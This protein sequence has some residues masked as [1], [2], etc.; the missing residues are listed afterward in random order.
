MDD[1]T[2]D[3]RQLEAFAAVMSAGSITGAA[4]LLGRSQPAVTRLIQELESDLGFALLHR[5]GPRITP[6]DKGVSF[7]EEIDRL[8]IGLRHIRDRADAIAK[9]KTPAIEVTATQSL[10]AG[11]VPA[12]LA[13]LKEADF[14][15]QVHLRASSAEDVVQSVIS[16]TADIGL[17]SLPIDHPG[18]DIHWIGEIACVAVMRGD[19]DL[20]SHDVLPLAALS[21][22]RII[23]MANP[24]RLRRR[25]DN[26][27][28]EA[29]LVPTE[30]IETNASLN[31][32]MSARAGLGV[33][34]VD[35]ATAFGIPIDGMVV[36]PLDI[37][38][39]FLFGVVTSAGHPLSRTARALIDAI[40][41]TA[42]DL[43]PAL[44]SRTPADMDG[45]TDKLYGPKMS[46][47]ILSPADDSMQ[48]A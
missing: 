24:F 33:A 42:T 45:L 27:I 14:P 16:R 20:A 25:I 26:A 23:T 37:H 46:P 6:T 2:L 48:E 28:A 15:G 44:I 22:R 9:A 21:Q 35:P 41:D 29:G 19:D 31:A 11:L 32:V 39:P 13:R 1:R 8:M 38:I 4:R 10:A 43:F 40:K 17:A 30:M 3:I 12:A 47:K 34:L 7:H 36:R 18:L 5:S